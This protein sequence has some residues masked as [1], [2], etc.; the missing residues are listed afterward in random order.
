S[1][2]GALAT[3]HFAPARL[4]HLRA[5][6]AR[7][8]AGPTD[9]PADLRRP[10]QLDGVLAGMRLPARSRCGRAVRR[11]G[12]RAPK[13]AGGARAGLHRRGVPDRLAP[14]EG[15]E[16]SAAGARRSGVDP[17]G[18]NARLASLRRDALVGHLR[19]LLVLE[20]S[21]Q[22]LLLRAGGSAAALLRA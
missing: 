6:H 18:G 5:K 9:E 1:S 22:S 11:G 12:G 16:H 7:V 3:S 8:P 2:G 21:L 13:G 4:L 17:R 10:P 14:W 19:G 15:A 20:L